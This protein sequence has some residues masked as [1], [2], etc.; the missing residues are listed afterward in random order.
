[1]PRIGIGT[2]IGKSMGMAQIAFSNTLSTSFDGVDEFIDDVGTVSDFSFIQNTGIFSISVWQKLTDF[3]ALDENTYM[4]NQNGAVNEAGFVYLHENRGGL[5]TIRMLITR[6]TGIV[7]DSVTTNDAITDNDWHNIICT[8][9]GTNVFYYI[10][11][12]K[13]TGSN[14]FGTLSSGDSTRILQ[15]GRDNNASTLMMD[16]NL[17]EISIWNNQLS[18][19]QATE[20]WNGG[21]P[22]DLE[23]HSNRANG[24]S[25][26]R[27]GDDDIFPTIIDHFGSNN[28][29]M[30]N[31]AA[32]NF[33]LDTP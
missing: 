10:D 26:H 20:I 1:M 6:T 22:G 14:T 5:R 8:G 31:M 16:G 4:G 25:W 18:D 15:I 30:T 24:V 9:D 21:A 28:G 7:I 27:M 33:Q 23:N 13:Q 19:A 3:S 12:V 11:N 2:G 29:T 32:N 17:D